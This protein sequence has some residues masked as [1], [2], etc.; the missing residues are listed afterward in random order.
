MRTGVRTVL[1]VSAAPL[2]SAC[3]LLFGFDG[4]D[5]SQPDDPDAGESGTDQRDPA[6][7]DFALELPKEVHVAAGR[8]VSVSLLLH[9]GAGF[10]GVVSLLETLLPINAVAWGVAAL[11]LGA[12]TCSFSCPRAARPPRRGS[13]PMAAVSKCA[14]EWESVHG[15]R[16]EPRSGVRDASIC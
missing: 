16:A 12:G 11:G 6:V 13:A 4:Y 8:S 7:T 14:S 1:V 10:D 5:T 9:R 3:A 15:R 2:V